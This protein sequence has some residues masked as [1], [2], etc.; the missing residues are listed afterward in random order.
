MDSIK[1]LTG[2]RLLCIVLIA[3]VCGPALSQPEANIIRV[4]L[5]SYSAAI[6][7]TITAEGGIIIARPNSSGIPSAGPVSSATLGISQNILTLTAND[8]PVEISD[9]ITITPSDPQSVL[10]ISAHNKPARRYRGSIEI[11]AGQNGLKVINI[12]NLE[13]Y[14]LGVLPA[15]MGDS[16]PESTLKAQAITA[17]TYV[18]ANLNKHMVVGYNVCDSSTCCQLY[19]GEVSEKPH[20]SKAVLDTCGQILTFDN[21]PASV[22]YSTDCGGI[23]RDSGL[24]YMCSVT[25]PEDIKHLE[26]R[27]EYKISDLA[28]KLTAA[29]IK[30]AAGLKSLSIENTDT[31][32]RALYIKITGATSSSAITA[33]RLQKVLGY[34]AIKS[35]MFNIEQ[36]DSNTVAFQGKGWGHGRGLCQVGAKALALPPHNFTCEQILA[37]YFPGTQIQTSDIAPANTAGPV[38]AKN[39]DGPTNPKPVSRKKSK[40]WWE[41]INLKIRL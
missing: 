30:E 21:K 27:Q 9:P 39:G 18:Y 37:H 8:K 16:Y 12:V 28:S 19:G 38:L 32:G 13:D 35:V 5:T 36:P 17:R 15:E 14:L 29:G 41:R 40:S 11:S 3:L 26:W 23:T 10:A 2:R 6:S 20:C 7:I 4:G 25:E 34:A 31:T 24:P 33:F 22:M 1:I